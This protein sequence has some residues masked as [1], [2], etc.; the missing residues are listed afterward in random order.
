MPLGL[1]GLAVLMTFALVGSAFARQGARPDQPAPISSL[2]SLVDHYRTLTWNYERA[3]H[4][5]KTPTSYSDRRTVDR[6]S[7]RWSIDA[8]TRRAYLARR[9]ALLK[10][11]RRL[12]VRLPKAPGL[13][14]QLSERVAYSRRLAL[15][16]R[17]IYPGRVTRRFAS[18]SADTGGE[19][20]RLWQQRSAL[21]AVSVAEHG[22][23]QS[24]IP[25]WLNDA[26]LCIHRYEGA[27]ASNTGNGYY[28]GLQM[29]LVFQRLYGADFVRRW[30]T[31]DNWPVWAQLQAAVRAHQSGRGFG[32]W[33]NT[34]RACG[35]V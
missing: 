22:L 2:R 15:S 4:S 7:L 21:A 18:A 31:A 25:A 1:A 20:L 14:A 12:R 29:D 23:A 26:F 28:G 34:A 30:G 33:P 24:P 17:R 13:R 6:S 16:L 11:E 10:I 8:W 3:A 5:K 19:T 9:E 32:P 35:L 27:W